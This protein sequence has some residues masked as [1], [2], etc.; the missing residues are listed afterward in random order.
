MEGPNRPDSILR[1]VYRLVLW[2]VAALSGLDESTKA[3]TGGKPGDS[4]L[5]ICRRACA[6]SMFYP[7]PS[8]Q[9]F[10]PLCRPPWELDAKEG[11][12][13]DDNLRPRIRA[14]LTK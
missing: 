8:L 9:H 14:D 10:D 12:E 6:L 7:N 2:C 5:P 3:W 4:C 1:L 13:P 11:R